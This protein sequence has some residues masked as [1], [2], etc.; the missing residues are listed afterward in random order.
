VS[1]PPRVLVLGLDGVGFA[2]LD[3]LIE[4]NRM[5]TVQRLLARGTRLP[6]MSTVPWQ[7]PVAWTSYATGT[8]P[9]VHGVY[10]WWGSDP[11]GAELAPVSGR[12]VDCARLWEVLS[13]AGVRVGT[14]NVP[15]S[16]PARPLNGFV[17]AGLDSVAFTPEV[18]P[19]F[20][21]PRGLIEGLRQEGID[22]QVLPRHRSD[23]PISEAATRWVDVETSRV[24]AANSLLERFEPEFLQVNLFATDYISHRARLGDPDLDF[25]FEASD[26]L[27]ARL[28]EHCGEDTTVLLMSDH[29]SCSIDRFV[30]IHNLLRQAGLLHF[31]PTVALE[32]VDNILEPGSAPTA[33]A[34]FVQELRAGGRVA[35]DELFR[36]V[37]DRLPGAN[38]GF[39]SIDWDRTRAYCV[40]DYGQ[41]R[42]NRERGTAAVRDES[43]VI[44]LRGE[45]RELLL[46]LRQHGID[47]EDV[48]LRE[49]VYAGRYL[50]RAPDLTPF[51]SS[52]A[53][54]CQVYALY[55]RGESRIVAPVTDVTDPVET[56]HLGDHV[57][58]GILI[59]TGPGI[60]ANERLDPASII[61]VAPSVLNLFN[62]DPLPEHHGAILGDVFGGDRQALRR[63]ASVPAPALR[64]DGLR[65]RLIDLGYRV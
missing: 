33:R 7:T 39:S 52:N 11:C 36:R 27:V 51:A 5:P 14:M 57:R 2:Y 43:E 61:D 63:P 9:G 3:N 45:V 15:M 55:G 31:L 30:M 44:R 37:A 60:A 29:G 53:Y 32:Q 56:G 40:S 16:Y 59:A 21:Y 22:Y 19:L 50:E 12:A 42:I 17:V 35:R 10:G 4:R 48:M 65:Q 25:V 64:E 18:D 58:D 41:V 28:L 47:V 49:E 38:V 20:A 23:E 13:A 24:E 1:R 62:L 6:L 26:G 54:F 34:R 8:N 46:G